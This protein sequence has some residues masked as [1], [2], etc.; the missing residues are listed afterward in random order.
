MDDAIAKL[1]IPSR[2]SSPSLC[3]PLAATSNFTTSSPAAAEPKS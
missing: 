3:L 2:D 1:Q